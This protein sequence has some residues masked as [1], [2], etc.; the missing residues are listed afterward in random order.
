[1]KAIVIVLLG[2]LFQAAAFAAPACCSTNASLPASAPTDKSLYQVETTWTSDLNKPFKLGQLTGRPQVVAMFFASCEYACPIL[3]HDIRKIEAG[4]KDA[5]LTNVGFVLVT[6]DVERDTAK[7]LHAYREQ[8]GLDDNWLLL[9][10][11]SEDTLEIAA[12]LGVKYKKDGR[13]QFAHSN[14]ITV[15]NAA[16]EIVHQQVGLNVDPAETIAVVKALAKN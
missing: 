11:T 15:L 9:R 14:I 6:M 4:L 2:A 10:G 13:G 12:L 3:V 7:R 1:M 5:G 8:R 16:G